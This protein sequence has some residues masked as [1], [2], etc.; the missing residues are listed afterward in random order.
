[1][2]KWIGS[3]I[4]GVVVLFIAVALLNEGGARELLDLLHQQMDSAIDHIVRFRENTLPEW[5]EVISNRL[6]GLIRS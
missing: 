5:A 1:M 6:Q 4:T 3:F 2:F